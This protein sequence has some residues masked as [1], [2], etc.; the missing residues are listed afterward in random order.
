MYI[1][2]YKDIRE[3][4]PHRYPML[5]VDGVLSLEPNVSIVAVKCVTGAEPCYACLPERVDVNDMAY[6]Q[7][8]V[9]ESF[10]QAGAILWFQSAQP[11]KNEIVLMLASIKNCSFE[12][13]VLPGDTMAHHVYLERVVGD[14]VFLSGE[15][16]VGQR[17][18]ARIEWLTMVVR[19]LHL[20]E[21]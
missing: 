15:T 12:A 19:S 7:S 1:L 18:I 16:R 11:V 8:L 17:Q 14:N 21:R 6:P 5:L 20:L 9:F 4:L 10:G 2:N 13:D 3:I